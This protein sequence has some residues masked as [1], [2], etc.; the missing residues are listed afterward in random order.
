MGRPESNRHL[1]SVLGPANNYLYCTHDSLYMNYICNSAFIPFC[2]L[3]QLE[4]TPPT[5]PKLLN[6]AIFMISVISINLPNRVI[7]VCAESKRRHGSAQFTP[8]QLR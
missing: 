6:A 7:C 4:E 2:K 3:Q 1:G 8:R 5:P